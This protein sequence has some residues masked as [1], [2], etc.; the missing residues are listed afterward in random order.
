MAGH[1]A[2]SSQ[3]KAAL[4]R[5]RLIYQIRASD[6]THATA[7][8]A[9]LESCAPTT[10]CRSAA[11]PICG[12]A[13]QQAAVALVDECIRE[14]ARAIR[15]RMSMLTIAPASGCIA[16]DDLSVEACER[17]ASEIT[18]AL[19]T[20]ALPPAVIG[21]E[22]SFNE[23]T[24]GECEPHWG[25]H[26]H[27]VQLDWLSGSQE[28]ALRAIFPPSRLVKRPV[29]CEPLD[30]NLQGRRYPFK[31]ERVRRVT[32]LKTDDPERRP[33]RDTRRRDLRPWQAVD[34]ALVEHDR[35]FE[36]RLL[37][38]RV[39]SRHLRGFVWARDGP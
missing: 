1:V 3:I 35:G 39:V 25:L 24:T 16:P 32:E 36:G 4:V 10:P 13:F 12:L 27:V 19:A 34:L 28:K 31:P 20:L 2:H 37:T 7:L 33:Y 21:F 17:V 38:H 8:A 15:N 29:K 6:K 9:I 23:D 14:P 22:V 18:T 26:G 5:R 30:Q 11:C